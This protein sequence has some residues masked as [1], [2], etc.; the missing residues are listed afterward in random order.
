MGDKGLS[1]LIADHV[2]EIKTKTSFKFTNVDG[3]LEDPKPN[4]K[5]KNEKG[6]MSWKNVDLND[7]SSYV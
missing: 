2:S 1:V 3:V 7:F 6:W 4:L 5:K